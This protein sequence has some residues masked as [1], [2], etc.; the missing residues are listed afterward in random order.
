MHAKLAA[1]F[2]A[3]A[4]AVTG[5]AMAAPAGA[6]TTTPVSHAQQARHCHW[7]HGYWRCYGWGWGDDD[8]WGWGHHH[9]DHDHGDWGHHHGD[10]H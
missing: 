10:R 7:Y 3:L 4:F 2:A 5:V 1:I 8:D 6:A 9:G